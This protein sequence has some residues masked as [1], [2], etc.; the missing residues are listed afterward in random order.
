MSVLYVV[1][2]PIG[3]LND[4]SSRCLEILKN[5]DY[6]IA[7]DTRHTLKLLSHYD[8]HKKLVSYHEHNEISRTEE[9][10][11]DLKNN[12][13]EIALVTDAGTPC[14]SDPG[15][16]IVNKAREA[17]I[18]VL[19]IPG[20]SAVITALSISGF[21]INSF[22]FYGF[23]SRENKQRRA[24]IEDIKKSKEEIFV[25]YESP[26]RIK[27]LLE[28]LIIEFPESEISISCDLTKLHEKTI[29]GKI[30]DIKKQVE[31]N[32][33]SELGEY[34]IIFKKI[35][36]EETKEEIS[37][38]ALLIDYLIKNPDTTLK[39]AKEE[40]ARTGVA[41]NKLYDAAENLKKRVGKL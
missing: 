14:I 31:E 30:E 10:I 15:Y 34:V 4:I 7:E 37:A 1:A 38:E 33:N 27:K 9:I 13:I 11:N 32:P 22:V 18:E 39:I 26:K 28:E 19:G 29:V 2:T 6:I 8:I 23:L 25:L 41:K 20:P 12:N 36:I 40:I 24:A 21:E 35:N 17:G 16:M 5:C 3:N